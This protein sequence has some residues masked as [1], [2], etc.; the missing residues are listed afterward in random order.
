MSGDVS[1]EHGG[2]DWWIVR[3]A[4]RIVAYVRSASA[5]E[6]VAAAFRDQPPLIEE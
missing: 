5:A 3:V 6:T 1:I 2:S 4:G